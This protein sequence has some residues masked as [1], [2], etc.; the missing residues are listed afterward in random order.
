MISYCDLGYIAPGSFMLMLSYAWVFAV[1]YGLIAIGTFFGI[2]K[3]FRS[4]AG[5]FP[6]VLVA[7]FWP[8]SA[9][10]LL[11]SLVQSKVRV[12]Q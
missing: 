3:N 5:L 8:V 7:L 1:L 9:V 11:A 2:R 10:A 6:D 12:K 4:L